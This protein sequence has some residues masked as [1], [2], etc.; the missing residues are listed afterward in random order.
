MLGLQQAASAADNLKIEIVRQAGKFVFAPKDVTFK[1]GESVEWFSKIP[2]APHQLVGDPP[3]GVHP[4]PNSNPEIRNTRR[5][6]L[7]L[8]N[9]PVYEGDHY[10]E[11]ITPIRTQLHPISS[12]PSGAGDHGRKG[13]C[14]KE[15][16][17]AVEPAGLAIYPILVFLPGSSL[18]SGA[19][20]GLILAGRSR[21][22]GTWSPMP[23]TGESPSL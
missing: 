6:E 13:N 9:S 2:N 8:H 16:C 20:A 18:S 11:M 22:I 21:N 4:S 14:R 17:R 3:F 23:T 19:F 15:I 1:A 12:R 10:R 5:H 7:S